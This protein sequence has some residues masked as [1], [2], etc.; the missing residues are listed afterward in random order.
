VAVH[1]AT[2][3]LGYLQAILRRTK[4]V[5]SRLY[6]TA[7][8]PWDRAAVGER[9]YFKVGGG[10][11]MAR[12]VVD[13]VHQFDGL[14]PAKVRRLRRD[15]G[16]AVGGDDAY[17]ASKADANYAV[18]LRLSHVEPMDVGPAYPKSAWRS[19]HVLD[20]AADPVRDVVLTA[21][22]IAN[23]YLSLAAGGGGVVLPVSP[24]ARSARLTLVLP[25]GREQ[26]TQLTRG[27][28]LRWRGWGGYYRA[29]AVRPGDVVRLVHLGGRRY[30]VAFVR[31]HAAA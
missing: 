24:Q 26:V 30:R 20:V 29:H 10:P 1:V 7:Q 13:E 6:K 5:E 2:L 23:R 27:S 12:A 19:W 28:M 18:M 25:D 11:F 16:P 17:W 3:K 4:T 31:A 15:W 8:P 9:V 21:G 14:T 22:A